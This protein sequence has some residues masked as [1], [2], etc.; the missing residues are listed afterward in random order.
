MNGGE[1]SS[2]HHSLRT[3]GQ[4]AKLEVS[5]ADMEPN[6]RAPVTEEKAEGCCTR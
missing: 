2:F 1:G 3:R 4:R 5:F 6:T